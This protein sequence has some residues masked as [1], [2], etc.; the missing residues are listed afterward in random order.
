MYRDVFEVKR[1]GSEVRLLA[2]LAKD[3]D[4]TART[5]IVAQLPATP[6]S[7]DLISSPHLQ[8]EQSHV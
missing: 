8:S 5:H 2:A 4:F 1:D 7:G 6:V 3:Q